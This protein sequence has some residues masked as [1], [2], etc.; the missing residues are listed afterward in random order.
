MAIIEPKLYHLPLIVIAGPTASGKTSLAIEI[1]KAYGG[2]I[3][4]ADS[5]SIYKYMNIGTAKPSITEREGVPHWGIDLV[6]PGEFFSAADFKSYALNK[7]DEIRQRGSMPILVGG[8]GLYIDAIIF[9][10]KFGDKVDEVIRRNLNNMNI[11]QLHEYCDKHNIQIPE[12]KL[13]KR[14]VI[15]NIERNGVQ[16]LRRKEPINNAIVVGIS[17]DRLILRT[18]IENRIEQLF[19]DGVVNEAKVLG[20]KYGW[21]NEAMKGNVYPL[22]KLYLSGIITIEEMKAKLVTI[23]WRLAKRQMTYLRRNSFIKWG[24]IN[25]SKKY[26]ISQLAKRR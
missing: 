11:P 2:E 5:R 1:A 26:I 22:A 15:R 18:R 17:T 7:I 16:F 6:C 23:D 24:T 8:T 10:Y 21:E 20:E 4:S 12:N 3:I 14:Y 9:D 19:D 25:E 13:N